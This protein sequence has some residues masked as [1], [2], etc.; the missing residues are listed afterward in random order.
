MRRNQRVAEEER[1]ISDDYRI[2]IAVLVLAVLLLLTS[3]LGSEWLQW[4]SRLFAMS[5]VVFATVCVVLPIRFLDG[6]RQEGEASSPK[7]S[8]IVIRARSDRLTGRSPLERDALTDLP[9]MRSLRPALEAACNRAGTG[10][11]KVA[12]LS[13]DVDRLTDINGCHG[14]SAGD[15]LLRQVAWRLA[16]MAPEA[17]VRTAGD[18]F[19]MLVGEVESADTIEL[20]AAGTIKQVSAAMELS[21]DPPVVV[22]PSLSGGMALWPDHGRD[23]DDL[24]RRAE[25]AMNEAKR[26]GGGKVRMFDEGMIRSLR[27]RSEMERDLEEAIQQSQLFLNF[28][29]QVNLATGRVSG[30]E[31]LMRWHHPERGNV[32]PGLFIP[33]AEKSGLIR[34]IGKWLI[35]EACHFCSLW[36]Q[37]GVDLTMAINISA[38]QLRQSDLPEVISRS[39]ATHGV[40]PSSIELELTESLFVD[41]TEIMMRRN[42]EQLA[43]MGLKLA[44]DD[45]GTG[46][47]SLAYLKRLPVGK[48][49]IDK[50]FVSGI[51]QGS[52]DEAIVR[53]IIGLA[54]T[55]GKTVVAEGVETEEQRAFLARAGCDLAQGY[56]FSKP[57]PFRQ[58]LRLVDTDIGS[59]PRIRRDERR[60]QPTVN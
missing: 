18:R 42:I 4:G 23:L 21:A 44:I 40:P 28:Q 54:D 33:V 57:M 26:Y 19:V 22:R 25:M 9:E 52:F 3:D 48:I 43:R 6:W 50:S 32:P 46:Y 45:F 36:R 8:T 13:F 5:A 24:L 7:K 56:L 39:L 14:F 1:G 16:S 27:K 37:Y 2:A 38:A 11:S 49:K 60:V 47:S 34:P 12:I 41:P 58:A 31:A 51:G 20:A 35:D 17:V 10:G 30:F 29:T 15:E 53:A 59:E 55:F